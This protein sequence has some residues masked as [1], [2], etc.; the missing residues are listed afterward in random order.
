VPV[1]FVVVVTQL[2]LTDFVN[3]FLTVTVHKLVEVVYVEVF[4]IVAFPSLERGL[5]RD[6]EIVVQ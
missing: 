6:P 1:V 4:V 5:E 2:P 3:N